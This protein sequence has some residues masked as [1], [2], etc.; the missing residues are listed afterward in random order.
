MIKWGREIGKHIV[1]V[2]IDRI[3]H[4]PHKKNKPMVQIATEDI[5]KLIIEQWRS[6]EQKEFLWI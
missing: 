3:T 2:I 5:R 1:K 6:D 4:Y